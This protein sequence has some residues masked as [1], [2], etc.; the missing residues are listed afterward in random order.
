M[1][2]TITSTTTTGSNGINFNSVTNSVW[3]NISITLTGT[4]S[5]TDY[6]H[7]VATLIQGT[8]DNTLQLLNYRSINS[9]SGILSQ[10]CGITILDSSYPTINDFY[11]KGGGDNTS[12]IQ[13]IGLFLS[14]ATIGTTPCISNGTAVGG[15]GTWACGV[16]CEEESQAIIT[17]VN[18][19]G[20]NGYICC[21]FFMDNA[22]NCT[23]LGCTGTG[24]N[25]AT[26]SGH[27]DGF[28]FMG[29]NASI[30]TGCTGHVGAN[31]SSLSY[32][33]YLDQN[34]APIIS[35]CDFT[36]QSISAL[37]TYTSANNGRFFPTA[38]IPSAM[39]VYSMQIYTINANPGK[40]I[41]V[42][43]YINTAEFCS[44]VSI[45]SAGVTPQFSLERHNT[46]LANDYLYAT[47]SGSI[48]N[49]DLR[50]YYTLMYYNDNCSALGMNTTGYAR[51]SDSYFFGC[52]WDAGTLYLS[53]AMATYLNW[54]IIGCTI[55]TYRSDALGVNAA[56]AITLC[57]IYNSKINGTIW[58]IT[59]F[60]AGT[61]V[62]TNIQ[63]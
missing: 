44:N 39:V 18:G 3:T 56:S 62:G 7:G 1:N 27:A 8:C 34:S 4:P 20:G 46:T 25:Y 35:A 30:V 41:K 50:I 9:C 36:P 32:S 59:S 40:T 31:P 60:A 26:G 11:A 29:N 17:N 28:Y 63:N 21:G 22:A 43:S 5:P 23:L 49:G 38:P 6:R 45:A 54:S 55:D 12:G 10:A 24:S 51:I 16:T 15:Y 14:I 2:G 13:N 19:Y 52:S 48:T 53:S 33:C 42:G 57:P 37:W 58:Q 61:A 47:P